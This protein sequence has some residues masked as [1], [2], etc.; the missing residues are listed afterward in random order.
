[1]RTI[2]P[3]LNG[4]EEGLATIIRRAVVKVAYRVS[5]EWIWALIT[6]L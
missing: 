5:V 3:V 2:A 4:R 1:M 6:K